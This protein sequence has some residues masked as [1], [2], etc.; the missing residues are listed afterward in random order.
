LSGIYIGTLRLPLVYLLFYFLDKIK[1]MGK[2]I[3]YVL[4]SAGV[5]V[6][7]FA[8]LLSKGAIELQW[9]TMFYE[10][11]AGGFGITIGM[12]EKDVVFNN[13]V[14]D[15]CHAPPS[16]KIERVCHYGLMSRVIAYGSDQRVSRLSMTSGGVNAPFKNV[17][18]MRIIL[19]PEDI[20]AISEN[21]N[22][23]KYTYLEWG[24]SVLVNLN[25][26]HLCQIL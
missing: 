8:L 20:L 3:R 24:I 13:G 11:P 7:L 16:F 15:G 21:F 18:D 14:P 1:V 12:H 26:T 19:G 5:L 23:R 10:P 4:Y 25:R 9:N 17:E 6:G 22:E 2:F